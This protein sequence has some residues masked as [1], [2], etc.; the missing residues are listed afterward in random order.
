MNN[1]ILF[2]VLKNL[3]TKKFLNSRIEYLNTRIHEFM[4]S[5]L[6]TQARSSVGER[7][8]DTVEVD[9]SILSVP[10]I[11]LRGSVSK[12]FHATCSE[13]NRIIRSFWGNGTSTIF[14]LAGPSSR[15]GKNSENHFHY[16][17]APLSRI[18]GAA[19]IKF[20]MQGDGLA[21]Q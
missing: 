2:F 16:L 4:N 11:S 7:Y 20:N 1:I 13:W 19:L 15:T 17:A 21:Q 18:F 5:C 8:I 9:S 10:T 6:V 3:E 12:I 14:C